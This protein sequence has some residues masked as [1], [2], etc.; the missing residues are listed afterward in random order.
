MFNVMIHEVVTVTVYNPGV[1]T[2]SNQVHWY[3]LVSVAH[4]SS[5]HNSLTLI[6]L[7]PTQLLS[8][9]KV[10]SMF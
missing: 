4:K 1:I 3:I 2:S 8:L 9:L 5:Q 10:L 7:E 6:C